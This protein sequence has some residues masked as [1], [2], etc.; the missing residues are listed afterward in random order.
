MVLEHNAYK[1]KNKNYKKKFM[2]PRYFLKARHDFQNWTYLKMSIFIK[3]L[4][5]PPKKVTLLHNGLKIILYHHFF[6]TDF[7]K[8]YKKKYLGGQNIFN[9]YTNNANKI[10]SKKHQLFSL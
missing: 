6:V 1:L 7:L 4:L 2:L 3:W 10:T 8:I 5:N 9:I